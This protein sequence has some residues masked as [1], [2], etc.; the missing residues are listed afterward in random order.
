MRLFNRSHTFSIGFMSELFA[1]Q[2]I[3][4]I[5]WFSKT[6]SYPLYGL[7]E[8]AHYRLPAQ[9]VRMNGA[10]NWEFMVFQFFPHIAIRIQIFENKFHPTQ[11][12]HLRQEVRSCLQSYP[13]IDFRHGVSKLALFGRHY[14]D[15]TW[16]RPWRSTS[17]NLFL[18]FS[19][20]GYELAQGG[21][22]WAAGSCVAAESTRRDWL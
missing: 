8:G 16:P 4:S 1:G 3:R 10:G 6:K 14:V 12:F 21:L 11:G 19:D 22:L 7:C 13:N 15:K 2:S 18:Y 9:I 5:P 20:D 17:S